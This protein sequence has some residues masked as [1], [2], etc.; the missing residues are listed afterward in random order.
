MNMVWDITKI[1]EILGR[2]ES[3]DSGGSF[4]AVA[5]KRKGAMHA[6]FLF[7]YDV[8]LTM[9]KPMGFAY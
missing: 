7:A 5:R 1:K 2:I 9:Y 3:H 4:S 8:N 6:P